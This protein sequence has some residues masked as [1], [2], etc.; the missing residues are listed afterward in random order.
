MRG[1]VSVDDQAD[2]NEWLSE[3]ITFKE[4]IESASLNGNNYAEIK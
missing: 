4:S 3:Q 1:F 2:Y